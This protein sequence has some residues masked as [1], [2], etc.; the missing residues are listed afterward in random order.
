M[1]SANATYLGGYS[2]HRSI[3]STTKNKRV[4]EIGVGTGYAFNPLIWLVDLTRYLH[5]CAKIEG[6]DI[7]LRQCPPTEWLTSNVLVHRLDCLGPMPEH[8]IEQYDV[9]HIQLPFQVAVHNND[10]GPIIQNLLHWPSRLHI[11]FAENGLQHLAQDNRMF[12]LELLEFQLDTAL[13]AWRKK[14][15]S[16]VFNSRHMLAYNVGRLTVVGQTPR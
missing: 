11:L 10:P 14:M 9:V 15:M 16:D 12:P 6:F 2:L 4:A 13:M 5:G 7:D 8:M 1:F 3:P